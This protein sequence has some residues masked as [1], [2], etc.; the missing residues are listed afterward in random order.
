MTEAEIDAALM[1][2][3]LIGRDRSGWN[4]L[5]RDPGSGQLWEVTYPMGEMHGGGPRA[6]ALINDAYARA[7]YPELSKGTSG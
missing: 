4:T 1:R 3:E 2:L 5:Y 7:K 6:L